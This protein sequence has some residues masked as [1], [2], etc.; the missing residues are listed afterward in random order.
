MADQGIPNQ[1]MPTAADDALFTGPGGPT[2]CI[3]YKVNSNDPCTQ[4]KVKYTEK[5]KGQLNGPD[6]LKE[7]C[8][9]HGKIHSETPDRLKF[10]VPIVG[11]VASQQSVGTSAPST[12]TPEP[13]HTATPTAHASEQQ[14]LYGRHNDQRLPLNE[15]PNNTSD[16]NQGLP[17]R[18]VPV[19]H[20]NQ[21]QNPG[22]R[23]GLRS[24]RDRP[25]EA[26]TDFVPLRYE[27]GAS[28]EQ[29]NRNV[30][31]NLWNSVLD[32]GNTL[33]RLFLETREDIRRN[34]EVG[35]VREEQYIKDLNGMFKQVQNGFDSESERSQCLA[36]N[37]TKVVSCVND[38]VTRLQKLEDQEAQNHHSSLSVMTNIEKLVF[39]L[40]GEGSEEKEKRRRD[41]TYR[42]E[43]QRDILDTD[44]AKFI[45]NFDD[46][47]GL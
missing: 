22:P 1:E 34:E 8:T 18:G 46:F 43:K 40:H 30:M 33:R 36:Q 28:F 15:Q 39:R 41:L 44:I 32:Q 11:N 35:Q 31:P 47:L 27:Q 26:A 12:S 5:Y 16:S 24:Q 25:D 6:I 2:I 29:S 7:L 10:V 14:Q 38:V 9:K 17:N 20:S 13:S 37:S 23:P 3:A 4:T 45:A 19:A 42:L 21:R